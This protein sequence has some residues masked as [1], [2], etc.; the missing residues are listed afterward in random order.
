MGGFGE[1]LRA[2][3]KREGLSQSELAKHIG[4]SKSSVNM[5]ERNEREP[6]FGTLEAIADFFNVNMD[7]LLGREES[8]GNENYIQQEIIIRVRCG[9]NVFS[10]SAKPTL[11][12]F[13]N[14]ISNSDSPS[15]SKKLDK[16]REE[17]KQTFSDK[18][19]KNFIETFEK[20]N[21]AYKQAVDALDQ[22]DNAAACAPQ[23]TPPA[24]EG[25]DT[26][27]PPDVPET[28]SEGE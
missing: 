7:Y 16:L 21:T 22:C 10:E 28:P 11:I 25:T 2:L 15:F 14:I 5:Y 26:P 18:D 4:V 17:M 3:R 23:P 12:K 27:P 1:R 20:I 9:A 6:G 13:S 24:S 19:Y 8:H